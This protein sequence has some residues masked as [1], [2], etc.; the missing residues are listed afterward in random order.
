MPGPGAGRGVLRPPG[1]PPLPRR[2]VHPQAGPAR[3]P[4]GAG[5]LPR[6]VRPRADAHRPG[7]RRLHAG[8][9][10]RAACG[11][12]SSAGCT[13]WRGSTGTRW[14]SAC[15]R[16]P[17]GLRIY[18]AGIVSSRGGIDLRPGRSLAQ[19]PRLRPGAGDAHALPDRRLPAGLFR[20]PVAAG[21]AGRH[22][23]GLRADLRAAGAGQRHP[24]RA[25]SSR[26]T[27]CSPAAPRPTP[28]PRLRRLSSR[29]ASGWR[30]GCRPGRRPAR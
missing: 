10:P 23:A 7:V 13:T 19:P 20:D 3:L 28:A 14:S 25:R 22:P 2:P 1:Q 6:R 18:G 9:W 8:L 30:A 16:R 27:R 21:A 29:A 12:W 26:P 15:C 17:Q 24:D 11:P 5:H 4:A